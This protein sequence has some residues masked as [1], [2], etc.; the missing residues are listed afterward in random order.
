MVL[1]DSILR[2]LGD[3]NSAQLREISELCLQVVYIEDM[4]Q[5]QL[6]HWRDEALDI[7]QGFEGSY[8][9]LVHEPSGKLP[10][11]LPYYL[12]GFRERLPFHSGSHTNVN[13]MRMYFSVLLTKLSDLKI[14]TDALIQKIAAESRSVSTKSIH[15]SEGW[16]LSS[17]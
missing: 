2:R 9:T 3:A 13:E 1:T 6:V 4:I 15:G 8:P 10:S 5:V 17:R 11:G 7:Y 14:R 12:Q 16:R